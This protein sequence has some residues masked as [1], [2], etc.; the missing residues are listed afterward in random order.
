MKTTGS[1]CR[2]TTGRPLRVLVLSLRL[3]ASTLGLTLRLVCFLINISLGIFIRRASGI[4]GVASGASHQGEDL[5][6][7]QLGVVNIRV[8]DLSDFG[9][10]RLGT[11]LRLDPTDT[12]FL[13]KTGARGWDRVLRD[14]A[15]A[16][17][18]PETCVWPDK[19]S[20][21]LGGGIIV[22]SISSISG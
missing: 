3:V 1:F 19:V 17:V 21:R 6:D 8:D 11:G 15:I 4:L 18:S 16:Q 9:N 20:P 10:E 22:L 2:R 13:Q 14:T 5:S 12:D 7:L